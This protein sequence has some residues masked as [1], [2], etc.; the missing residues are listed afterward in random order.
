LLTDKQTDR[1]TD[2]NRPKHNLLGG[3]N[4][5]RLCLNIFKVNR[6][7]STPITLS[8]KRSAKPVS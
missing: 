6:R 5:N 1:Q 2:K 8:V 7:N 4:Y 3:G